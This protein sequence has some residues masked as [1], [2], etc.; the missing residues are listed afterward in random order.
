MKNYYYRIEFN[1]GSMVRREHVS[2]SI[3]KAAYDIMAYEM[4]LLK[5]KSVTYGVMK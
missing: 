3:A 2:K 1:D 4:H 5:V